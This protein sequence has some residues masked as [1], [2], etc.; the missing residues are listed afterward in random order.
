MR[1]P[2]V[3]KAPFKLRGPLAHGTIAY[4][5][6]IINASFLDIAGGL[7]IGSYLSSPPPGGTFC[8]DAPGPDGR[9]AGV[10]EHTDTS[11]C[12]QHSARQEPI[13]LRHECANLKCSQKVVSGAELSGRGASV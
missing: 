6:T 9:R 11:E 12:V 2:T 10:P 8:A 3:T 4:F 1:L 7:R 5:R 13:R